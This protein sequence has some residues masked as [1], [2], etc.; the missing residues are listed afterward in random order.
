MRRRI[1]KRWVGMADQG[2]QLK[3]KVEVL[4]GG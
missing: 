3:V 1:T 4:G 2:Q